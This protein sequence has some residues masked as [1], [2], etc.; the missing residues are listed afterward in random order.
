MTV[1]G[2]VNGGETWS[3]EET[4]PADKVNFDADMLTIDGNWLD[5]W[6]NHLDIGELVR[7]TVKNATGEDNATRVL[8]A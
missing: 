7:F 2:S 3:Y 1:A 8:A 5:A 6:Y 4:I